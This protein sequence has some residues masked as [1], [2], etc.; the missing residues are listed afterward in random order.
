MLVG[1]QVDVHRFGL[2]EDAGDAGDQLLAFLHQRI[3]VLQ[4]LARVLVL[5]GVEES[6]FELDA[7]AAEDHRAD[8]DLRIRGIGLGVQVR[9]DHRGFVGADAAGLGVARQELDLVAAGHTVKPVS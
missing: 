9:N 4:N 3:D 2:A 1:L 6:F 5:G 7:L 8:G